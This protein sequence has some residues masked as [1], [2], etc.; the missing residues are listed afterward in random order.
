MSAIDDVVRRVSALPTGPDPAA[1]PAVSLPG[2]NVW[3]SRGTDGLV[4]IFLVDADPPTAMT[5]LARAHF[6]SGVTLMLHGH[7]PLQRCVVVTFDGSVDDRV[8]AKIAEH[9]Q[10][11]APHHANGDDLV[12]AI[13]HF[14]DSVEQDEEPRWTVPKLAGLWGELHLIDRLLM[15]V[16]NDGERLG[17]VAAWK[18]VGVHCRDL[19]FNTTSAA[20]EVKTTMRTSRQHTVSSAG[21]FAPRR[22]WNSWL[23]SVVVRR[24]AEGEGETVLDLIARIRAHLHGDDCALDLFNDKVAMLQLDEELASELSLLERSGRPP[25]L[26][27]REDVPG[28]VRFLGTDGLPPG[29]PELSWPV[30][31]GEDGM[32]LV[33]ARALLRT[34]IDVE[35]ALDE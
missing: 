7:A 17:V 30:V 5:S 29:V 33:A 35:G 28:V 6:E 32:D 4:S 10:E 2:G 9:V 15:L 21:Q 11:L 34:I 1:S 13:E 27:A 20:I 12:L 16:R 26:F 25:M 3:V 23:H 8:V 14:R 31:L 18:S 24:V 19:V 22:G